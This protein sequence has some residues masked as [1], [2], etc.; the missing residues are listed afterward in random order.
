[1]TKCPLDPYAYY[2]DWGNRYLAFSHHECV[3]LARWMEW[4][5]LMIARQ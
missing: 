3:K 4:V 5:Y 2:D 1:M